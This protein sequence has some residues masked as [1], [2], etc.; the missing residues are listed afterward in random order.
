V[1]SVIFEESLT[2]KE[3]R[4]KVWDLVTDLESFAKCIPGCEEVKILDPNNL[5]ARVKVK[6]GII[7]ARFNV[8]VNLS[9]VIRPEH[10]ESTIKGIDK[11]V[12]SNF[13]MKSTVDFQ[14]VGPEETVVKYAVNANIFGK[15]GMI[16]ATIAK[17]KAS[18]MAKEFGQNINKMV[19]KRRKQTRPA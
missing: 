4:E 7:S 5:I 8:E 13:D 2:I 18:S 9:N 17:L 14:E 11:G 12:A 16:G 3:N 1:E 6:V 15:L 19:E 10:I